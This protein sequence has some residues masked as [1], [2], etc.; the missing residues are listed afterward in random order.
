MMERRQLLKRLGAGTTVATLTAGSVVGRRTENS[1]SESFKETIEKAMEVQE[2]A[3]EASKNQFLDRHGLGHTT[4]EVKRDG[5]FS[6]GENGDGASDQTQSGGSVSAQDVEN[7]QNGGIQATMTAVCRSGDKYGV[8]LSIYYEFEAKCG[9]R[10]GRWVERSGGA[11]PKDAA[12]ISWNSQQNEYFELAGS[13]GRN[14]T[15]ARGDH[16]SWDQDLHDVSQGRTGFRFDDEQIYDDWVDGL[17]TCSPVEFENRTLYAGQCGVIVEPVGNW[18][19]GRRV[20]R[21]DYAH[22]YGSFSIS[23]S[24]GWSYGAGPTVSFSPSWQVSQTNISLNRQGNDLEVYP[25][26]TFCYW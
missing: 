26:E 22:S 10:Q 7:A 6:P 14:A 24:V 3:G 4:T 9:G 1:R 17:P 21:A 15:L 2:E 8:W 5:V 19:S 23:P 13:G 16:V 11:A 25:Q 18:S 12:G 20:V